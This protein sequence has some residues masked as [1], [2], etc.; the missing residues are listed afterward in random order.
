VKSLAALIAA[1][2]AV[3]AIGMLT[4]QSMA[5]RAD[6]AE[7][8]RHTNDVKQ[9]LY[10]LASDIKDVETAQRG[11]I[12]TGSER[13]LVP[14]E[15]AR[16]ALP[17]EVAGLRRL[18]ADNAEQSL[19]LD[20]LEPLLTTKLAELGQTIAQKRAGDDAGAL[21]VVR[22]DRGQ[23]V[24][25]RLRQLTDEMLA[26][27][28]RLLVERD[29][30]WEASVRWSSIVM[31]GGA[32]ILL[33]M[34]GLL[35]LFASRDFRAVDAEAWTRRVQLALGAHL[36][37]DFRLESLGEKV[38][39]VMAEH[40]DARVGAMY[41]S[42]PGGLRRVAGLA[43]EP[44]KAGEG[45]GEGAGEGKAAAPA[46][47]RP[48]D[49]LTG[50]AA[51]DGRLAHVRDL[52]AGYLPIA[53]AVGRGEPRELVIAP[54][55]A[56]GA[57]QAVL[58]LGF[59]H[60]LGPTELAA[61]ERAAEM[62]ATAVRTARDRG[63]LEELLEET[64]RQ[65]EELQAQQEE[66]RVTNEELE[67][68]TR[69]LTASQTQLEEQQAELEQINTQLEDQT[70]SLAQQRDELQRAGAEL[71]RV[72]EYKSQFLANMS[73]ELR[74]PLNSSLIL[75]KLLSDNREGNLSEEQI[76][77]AR[78][79][80][81]A[82]NDLLTLINDILDLSKIEAGKL[83]VRSEPIP[84]ARVVDDL[85][86]TF[87]PVAAQKRLQ[88]E[89]RVADETPATI[90][91]DPTRLMQILKNLLSN[92]LKFTETG[93][94][95]FEVTA[96]G[97][98][99]RFAVRDTGIG[100]P[101]DQHELI[102]EAFRQA[103]GASNRKFGGTGLGLSISRDLA[104]LL[105]GDLRL[106]S[107]PGH[108]STFT[109]AL[110]ARAVE[111]PAG[112]AAVAA[113]AAAAIGAAGAG[114]AA[115]AERPPGAPS[116]AA[117]ALA[118]SLAAIPPPPTTAR[119]TGAIAPLAR[120]AGVV[121]S[122]GP[123]GA[124]PGPFPDDRDRVQPGARALLVVEDDV[125][126]ARVIFDLAHEL[127]FLCLVANTAEAGLTLARHYQPSAIVLDVG[128]PDRSG[129]AVLD[130]LKRDPRTRHV[131][132]HVVSAADYTRAALAMGAAGY[133]LKPVQ[134]EQLV[135]AIRKL[136]A[137]FTQKLRRVL[138]VEDDPN[139]RESTARLLAGDDVETV[140]V[141][142]TAEA[143]ARLRAATFD[144]MVLDLA[145]PDGSG[146][147]LLE[148]MARGEYGFPPVIVY[149][150]RSLS[151]DQ[152]RELER[153]SSAIVI[154]GARSPERLLDEVTLFLHQVEAKL[155]P[156]R[157][158]MLRDVRDREAVFEGRRI[159][160]VED[161]VRNLFALSSVLEPKGAIVELAR[162]GREALAH[163]ER[164]P[165]VDLV[166]MDIMMPEMDGI[167]ATREIRRRP[168]LAGVPIIALT[169][170]AMIDDRE[171]CLA[172]GANDY[173]AKPLSVDKLLSLARVWIRK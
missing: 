62:I 41:V 165:D 5:A 47:I 42:E 74:T 135:D 17:G 166:L 171:R 57:V 80:Y 122:A 132:V 121:V 70:Q 39:E 50:Q 46:M 23:V 86:G 149:T 81:A 120:A 160:I 64:Q 89:V 40:L 3:V 65:A 12:L 134:R 51:R 79:I 143:L 99:I 105:G 15:T 43:L 125:T 34:L 60:A 127:E 2:V 71:S 58:E 59:L 141:G 33:A 28:Q 83:D 76:K 88:L 142:T 56:D 53:S 87:Q 11:F 94:V 14:Y 25:E 38:L 140:A 131:P 73:H 173:I 77:F 98:E 112:A 30:D 130:S 114:G 159:L 133:A 109:L 16:A 93:G 139:L 63:R 144:C 96:S 29:K 32:A 85:L 49:S 100:I 148:E 138:V 150:G 91:T 36:R 153:F 145:L 168:E 69:A 92:A 82:G 137:K 97:G 27:E 126:F 128:L 152:I 164:D 170:K 13:Y 18:T 78:T 67:Q 124:P 45:K 84:V 1:L 72:N 147:E 101:A 108:G 10:R 8:I 19:R 21:A 103:D 107:A 119:G 162:N 44:P 20:A 154:K 90:E 24:M 54:A 167:E 106:E 31:F 35:G 158:R 37:G 156:D 6:A 104:R 155:P 102:F 116:A 110:P 26:T 55:S 123:S 161:D 52:P 172:A 129:L 7:W 163:L 66:L 146:L 157:Q 4:Y 136:E 48:G 151:S 75:A 9:L 22:S 61:M 115:R 113:A 117:E 68:H 118:K 169:A 95:S 111:R